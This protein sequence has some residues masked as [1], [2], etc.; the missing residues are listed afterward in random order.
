MNIPK[1][2]E[3]KIQ[4]PNNKIKEGNS[5]SEVQTKNH[6]IIKNLY[7]LRYKSHNQFNF[8][9][10]I[11]E[12]LKKEAHII[13]KYR[14]KS[15]LL[16][17]IPP[18][19]KLAR[20]HDSSS[21][22][23]QKVQVHLLGQNHQH[24]ISWTNLAHW[25]Q[26]FHHGSWSVVQKEQQQLENWQN[27]LSSYLQSK[28]LT[29]THLGTINLSVSRYFW[30]R[31]YKTMSTMSELSMPVGTNALAIEPTLASHSLFWNIGLWLEKHKRLHELKLLQQ[32][33]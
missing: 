22:W 23:V 27:K 28:I 19:P 9:A 31:E 30:R 14:G 21:S 25:N 7:P 13:H 24:L 26:Y 17:F 10:T 11:S 1:H 12:A 16:K 15:R 8:L 3:K 32:Q 2:N 33:Q 6:I 18:P 4:P 29:V 5:N 20:K